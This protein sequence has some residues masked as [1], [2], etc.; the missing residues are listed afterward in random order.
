MSEELTS[1][2]LPKLAC[3]IWT[4]AAAM[5]EWHSY[6]ESEVQR[7]YA[8][9]FV[10]WDSPEFLTL[11]ATV[12][13]GK[14]ANASISIPRGMIEFLAYLPDDTLP[15]ILGCALGPHSPSADEPSA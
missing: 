12:G 9:G 11:S 8:F 6:D 2:E 13:K 7:C 3:I 15:L 5:A 4:D 14:E 1:Y 10:T